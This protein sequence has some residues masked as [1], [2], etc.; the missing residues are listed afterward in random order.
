MGRDTERYR[1]T[2]T[3]TGV[4]VNCEAFMQGARRV[5]YLIKHTLQPSE[6]KDIAALM[7]VAEIVLSVLL[8]HYV[9]L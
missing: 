9:L 1:E 7:G 5:L 8:L 6:W 2:G 4:E 3:I